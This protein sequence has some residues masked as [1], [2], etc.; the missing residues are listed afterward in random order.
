MNVHTALF[1]SILL[2]LVGDYLTQN[3]W[4]ANHKTKRTDVAL[5]HVSLYSLPFL[6][7]VPS[8]YWLVV[9]L[10]HFFIDR[11]RL[12]VYWI[13]LVNWNWQSKN[14][15]FADD[16]PPFLSIWLMII[17][18]NTFH[19]VFNTIAIFMHYKF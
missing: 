10:S 16:K 11:Y 7:I 15:G 6:V 12:A 13:K 18:D 3:D 1:L 5:L 19:L 9:F 17:I 8:A 4:I 2:H 14:L